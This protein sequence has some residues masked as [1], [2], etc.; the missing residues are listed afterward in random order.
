MSR[1]GSSNFSPLEI[2]VMLTLIEERLPFGQEEYE[3]LASEFNKRM[4]LLVNGGNVIVRSGESLK[5]KFKGLKNEQNQ[6]K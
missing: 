4:R 1:V 6:F 5:N 2:D 3:D